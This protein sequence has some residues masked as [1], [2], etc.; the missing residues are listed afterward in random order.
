MKTL[1]D[2]KAVSDTRD[3]IKDGLLG[4]AIELD[5]GQL[6]ECFPTSQRLVVELLNEL[7]DEGSLRL[8]ERER[9]VFLSSPD[10][11]QRLSLITAE[12]W[13]KEDWKDDY[14]RL[15]CYVA[16]SVNEYGGIGR[17]G[18]IKGEIAKC[19]LT[20]GIPKENSMPVRIGW[21]SFWKVSRIDDRPYVTKR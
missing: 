4:C 20:G 13:T 14:A 8:F 10:T 21:Q 15:M 2:V 1:M 5:I 17:I 7:L 19:L 16:G 12:P 11:E 9:R 6:P 3:W 18:T